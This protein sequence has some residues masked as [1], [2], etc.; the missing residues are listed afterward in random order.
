MEPIP[1]QLDFP[2]EQIVQ[3]G[4]GLVWIPSSCVSDLSAAAIE[5][6][7]ERPREF[8]NSGASSQAFGLFVFAYSC[9]S[10]VGPIVIGVIREKA[11]WGA[12]TMTLACASVAVCI[13]I[14][15]PP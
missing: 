5:L 13:P 9:G 7:R 4:L 6:K 14:V 15:S 3:K 10:L 11:D 2:A 8:G 1:D 12:A